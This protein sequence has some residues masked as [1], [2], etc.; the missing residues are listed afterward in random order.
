MAGPRDWTQNDPVS[1]SSRDERALRRWSEKQHAGRYTSS[2][3]PAF[4]P[5]AARRRRSGTGSW[6]VALLSMGV[7]SA[8][9]YIALSP[10]LESTR[11]GGHGYVL[12]AIGLTAIFFGIAAVRRNRIVRS[13]GITAAASLG[14]GLGAIA[15]I[16]MFAVMA[17]AQP[18]AAGGDLSLLGPAASS[19]GAGTGFGPAGVTLTSL[20]VVGSADATPVV[21]NGGSVRLSAGYS[22]RSSASDPS[23]QVRLERRL[24]TG[25]W[26]STGITASVEG[27]EGP[28]TAVTPPY[29]TSEEKEIVQ[30][31]FAS[32][33]SASAPVSV[34]Y[35]NQRAYTGMAATI[36]G[37]SAPYCPATAVRIQ[38]LAGREAGEY[39]TGASL[40]LIDSKIGVSVNLSPADQR[41]VALHECS[42]EL[43]W[44]NYGATDA[45]RKQMEAAAATH[46]SEGANGAAPL[47]HA[48][49][50]GAQALEPNGYLGYG[51]YCTS[52]ELVL[53][54]QLLSGQRY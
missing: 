28:L 6:G 53:G 1:W 31:R 11:G 23:I 27:G 12:T 8:A 51:G 38:R 36:Y 20:R 7:G 47:E 50:C 44:L 25:A 22:V 15:S 42:H 40:I 41:S 46:F 3:T 26:S 21:G 34:S 5:P 48:A 37:Y 29:S 39:R 16:A 35:E 52:N 45:G 32:T 2:S 33:S 49:D 54:R 30:Y 13:V 18:P 14:I 19:N 4:S 9:V 17:T 10:V 24:G 43:Q